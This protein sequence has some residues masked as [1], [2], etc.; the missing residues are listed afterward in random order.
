M[1]LLL[2][3]QLL[4]PMPLSGDNPVPSA[5]NLRRAMLLFNEFWLIVI[6]LI[7][8]ANQVR[9]VFSYYDRD[10]KKKTV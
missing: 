5:I 6:F 1:L 7:L 3:S 9:K 2:R 4:G 10:H 8:S